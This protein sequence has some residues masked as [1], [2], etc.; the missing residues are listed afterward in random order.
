MFLFYVLNFFIKGDIIQGGTLFKGGHYLRKYGNRP[1]YSVQQTITK[2]WFFNFVFFPQ[3][4]GSALC[5]FHFFLSWDN[6]VSPIRISLVFIYVQFVLA[7]ALNSRWWCIR[8]IACE[9]LLQISNWK[10]FKQPH[11]ILLVELIL[12]RCYRF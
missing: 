12:A 1:L 4:G 5:P 11:F 2:L 3:H 6:S 7:L 9:V 8:I 10:R